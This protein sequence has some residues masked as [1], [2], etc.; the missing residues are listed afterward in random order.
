MAVGYDTIQCGREVPTFQRYPAASFFNIICIF[1]SCTCRCVVL[2]QSCSYGLKCTLSL[3]PMKL[4][5]WSLLWATENLHQLAVNLDQI[6]IK[7]K[8]QMNIRKMRTNVPILVL[9]ENTW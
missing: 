5:Q 2:P 9:I 3:S 4:P 1:M 8:S 6:F 7:P